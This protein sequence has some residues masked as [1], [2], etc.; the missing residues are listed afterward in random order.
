MGIE[1]LKSKMHEYLQGRKNEMQ[2]RAKKLREA[3][4]E[5]EAELEMGRLAVYDIFETM[6]EASALKAKMNPKYASGDKTRAF[7][8]EY[9]MT[10]I[11]QPAQ[12]RLKYAQAKERGM[13]QE[14]E[15]GGLRLSTVQEIKDEFLRISKGEQA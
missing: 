8:Q 13:A 12:W 6:L 2:A 15:L 9:L 14:A 1:E 3:G 11:T 5:R 7:K 4:K 10:F